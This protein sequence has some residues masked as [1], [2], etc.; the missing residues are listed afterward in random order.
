MSF[1]LYILLPPYALFLLFFMVMNLVYLYH[2]LRY[3]AAS[4]GTYIFLAC[5]AVLVTAITAFSFYY[6]SMITWASPVEFIP[7]SL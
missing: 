4:V 7:S 6:G 5:Y 3:S 2:L 1:P